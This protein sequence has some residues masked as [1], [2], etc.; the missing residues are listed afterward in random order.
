MGKESKYAVVGNPVAHSL[1]PEIHEAFAKQFGDNISYEKI[2]IPLGEFE[3]YIEDLISE[4]YKGVNVTI[5]FKVDAYRFSTKT[6]A[7]ARQATA[8]NTLKFEGNKVLGENTDGIGFVQDLKGRLNFSLKNKNILILGAGGSVRGLLPVIL[9][10][11]PKKISVANRSVARAQQLADEFG[12]Q[13]ILYD[14]TGSEQYDLIINATPASLQNKAPLIP[15]NAF[16]DCELAFD[17][18]YAADPTPFMQVAK[19]GGAKV[20]SDGLGM[21][22]EQAAD[23]YNFWLGHRPETTPVYEYIR[24]LLAKK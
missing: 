4:G 1:S 19:E 7:Y 18:V 2:E 20:T 12:I 16:E 3:S 21:L 17:L 8:A 15:A 22:V 10:E 24:K 5:T 6:T 23:S 13:S 14:E 9:D 11:L